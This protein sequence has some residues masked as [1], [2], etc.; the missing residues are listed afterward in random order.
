MNNEGNVII[1]G[2][3]GRVFEA[4]LKSCSIVQ[5][6][7]WVFAGPGMLAIILSRRKATAMRLSVDG[8]GRSL[9][10]IFITSQTKLH[11]R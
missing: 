10:L 5:T 6:E 4:E 7:L 8:I 3:G 9:S 1:M 11:I 2:T